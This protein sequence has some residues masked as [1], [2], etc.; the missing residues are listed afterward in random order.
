[1]QT[2]NTSNPEKEQ[3]QNQSESN[4]KAGQR[5]DTKES[6]AAA[7]EQAEAD[8]EQDP[9]LSSKPDPA[10]DLDEGELARLDNDNDSGV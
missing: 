7:H 6:V 5:H 1:M 9:E 10:A 4:Q 8:I 2:D 3:Q